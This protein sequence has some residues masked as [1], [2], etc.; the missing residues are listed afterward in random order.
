FLVD[1]RLLGIQAINAFKDNKIES[2]NTFAEV[3]QVDE[4]KTVIPDVDTRLHFATVQGMVKR[5]FYQE[6]E[7][8]IPPVDTY[9]CII[10][11]EAHRGY[12][13]DKE[14]GDDDLDFKNQDD[15]VSKYR[16]VLEY[17]D[18]YAI[19]LTATPALHTK[20]IFE[21]PVYT[22]SYREA[23]IDG[24]LIDHEPPHLIKTKLSEEG[25]LWEKG[26][27]PKAY[28]KESN[29]IVE[30]D[31]LEDE[32]QIEIEG[33]NR[34]VL[35]EPFNRTVIQHLV[36]EIDP[37]GEE[38]TLIFAATDQHADLIVNLLVEAYDDMGASVPEDAIQ[39]IT[40]KSYD[41]QELLKRFR[42]EKYPSIA[43]TVDLISSHL[44]VALPNICSYKILDLTLR[45]N[46]RLQIAGTS[47]PV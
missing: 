34:L 2:L 18:A 47:I 8:N 36:Q 11:D 27:K 45:K 22:Y 24:F 21:S 12:L 42:N 26:E 43:V 37:E 16:K 23:V 7:E 39:K 32:L 10:I 30:L 9:D 5:L 35:T 3:Y 29:T 13:L 46:T 17:F 15:Y 31:E 25:I 20:K 44:R 14:M 33:F 6:D 19:G 4:L 1:R 41:P 38:K 40:G 28:D